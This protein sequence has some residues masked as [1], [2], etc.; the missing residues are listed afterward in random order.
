[1]AVRE[2]P[3]TLLTGY[4]GAGKT[5]LLNHVLHNKE[6]LKVAVIVNDVGEVNIDTT[7]I[8]TGKIVSEEDNSLISLQNGCICCNLK[9]DLVRQL[10]ELVDTNRFDAVLIEAS[11][12]SEPTPVVQSVLMVQQATEYYRLPTHCYLNSVVCV[13]D[14]LRLADEFGCGKALVENKQNAAAEEEQA[15]V[16]SLLV[17]QIEFCNRIVLNKV[18]KVTAEEK[19]AVMEMLAALQPEAKVYEAV[20]GNVPVK[21][22]LSAKDFDFKKTATS[23]GWMKALQQEVKEHKPG[24]YHGED[25]DCPECKEKHHHEEHEH[26]H[27]HHHE[28]GEHCTC[29]CHDHEHGHHGHKHTSAEERFGIQTFVYYVR[30]PMD[31]KRFNEFCKT[32]YPEMI[33]TKGIVWFQADPEGMYVFEQAG[34]QFECYQADNWVAAYP[35]KE[36]EEFIASHPDIKKD[37]H[38]VWGDRMVKLV[39]IGKNLNTHELKKRLDTCLA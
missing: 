33:R 30:R 2:M 25:C 3:V 12:V 21:E 38:E 4:L 17:E 8:G 15:K 24:E 27:E 11:G 20:K 32:L 29:G 14:A 34:K 16:E 7:L 19:Q 39:F 6:G 5:T 35:K 36:R 1:M 26:H 18:D 31:I 28:H 10:A 22:L 37:W 13:V 9:E 23:A